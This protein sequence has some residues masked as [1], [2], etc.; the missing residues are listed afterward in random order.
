MVTTLLL[1]VPEVPQ[2][3]HQHRHGNKEA[4]TVIAQFGSAFFAF[5]LPLDHG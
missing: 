1:I 5:E 2:M 4:Q 3:E